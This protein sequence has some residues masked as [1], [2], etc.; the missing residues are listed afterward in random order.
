MEMCPRCKRMSASLNIDKFLS[1]NYRSCGYNEGEFSRDEYEVLRES[2]E[3][4]RIKR[5]NLRLGTFRIKEIKDYVKN[6]RVNDILKWG[7]S[8]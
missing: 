4:E 5:R 3:E 7:N 6:G 1:C 2:L 8:W